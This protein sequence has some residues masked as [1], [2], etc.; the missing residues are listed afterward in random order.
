MIAATLYDLYKEWHLL[1]M[2]DFAFF[3]TGFVVSF[4]S[5]AAAVKT[6]IAIVQKWSLVPLHGTD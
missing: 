6:F 4:I 1:E 5:A 2:S 3:A